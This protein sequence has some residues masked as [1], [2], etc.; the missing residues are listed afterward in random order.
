MNKRVVL[1][2]RPGPDGVPTV[3]NFE[4]EEC[5]L[6]ELTEGT[7]LVKTL[8]LSVDPY[9]RCRMNM[10]TGTDY[11]SP[12]RL[13]Q[14]IDGGGVGIIVESRC[15]G[16]RRGEILESFHWPWQLYAVME[17]QG[18]NCLLVKKVDPALIE[19]HFSLICG[20]FGLNGQAAFIG[21]REKGHVIPEANQTFVVSAAAGACGS[22]AG[23]IARL[24]GCGLIVGICGSDQKCSFLLEEL[25]FS[26]AIN[27]K[28][29]DVSLRIKEC[30]PSGVDIYFD[31]VGGNISDSV[32][33]QMNEG[34][35]I[36][37][38]GQ[39]AMYNTSTPYPPPLPD[40]VER[41]RKERNITR[42]RFLVLNY[43]DEFS[44]AIAQLSEW[45]KEGKIKYH[46]TV[47]HGLESAP[48]AFLSMM[49]GGNIGKQIVH[50]AEP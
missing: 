24:Q 40:D 16:F 22:L 50:V 29:E 47:S 37:L 23:Q 11:V 9:M 7:V 26:H 19:R 28:T 35:H 43:T 46:E 41:T 18:V 42:D 39:I 27:Y 2:S 15:R 4:V 6:P 8:C 14:T 13:D 33:E 5:P 17:L 36:I 48:S 1:T 21:I 44:D 34:S 30:C 38:C 49:S 10:D 32:I 12:W 31:N 25:S 20:L 45:F 3:D